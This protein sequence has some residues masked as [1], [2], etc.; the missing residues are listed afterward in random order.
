MLSSVLVPLI[1]NVSVVT[2]ARLR[3]HF[4]VQLILRKRKEILR[5]RVPRST[6]SLP[7]TRPFGL[8]PAPQEWDELSDLRVI[9]NQFQ[10]DG[11]EQ[12]SPDCDGGSPDTLTL[13]QDQGVCSVLQAR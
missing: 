1:C 3:L 6:K 9:Q 11:A 4:P 10:G 12:D 5:V 13:W 2:Q 8:D 7:A